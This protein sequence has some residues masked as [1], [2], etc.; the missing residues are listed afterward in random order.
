MNTS[1]VSAS[2]AAE[3][4]DHI[5]QHL[6][7]L[8]EACAGCQQVL[9]QSLTLRELALELLR[10]R[11]NDLRTEVGLVVSNPDALFLNY[12]DKDG[13]LGSMAM[14]DVLID[15][16]RQSASVMTAADAAFYTRHDSLDPA[17]ALTAVQNQKLK[18]LLEDFARILAGSYQG[19]LKVF[20]RKTLASPANPGHFD[21]ARQILI[22]QHRAALHSEIALRAISRDASADDKTRL[23]T[24]IDSNAPEGVFTLSWVAKDGM[25]V[26]LPFAY[27]VNEMPGG[28][29]QPSGAVYLV[30]PGR[31]IEHI[32]SVALVRELLSERL[33]DI[34][35][36][37][38]LRDSLLLSDQARLET[39]EVVEP[40]AWVFESLSGPLLS[41]HVR[42]LQHKQLE[43]L[44]FLLQGI[45]ENADT[46]SFHSELDRVRVCGH[47]D[48]AMGR[49]F[50]S[51][52][53]EMGEIVQPDWR[54]YGDQG[55]KDH[56][57]KLES[58]YHQSKQ[59]LEGVLAGVSSLENFARDEI[60]TYVRQHLGCFIDPDKVQITLQDAI[61]LGAGEELQMRY[62]KSLLEF[63]IQGLPE[64]EILISPAPNDLH[65]EFSDR[66]VMTMINDLNLHF[67]YED[68]L[69]RCYADET[70]L[71]SMTHHRDSAIELGA[72]AASMQGHMV[73]PRSHD[74][75]HLIRGDT[76]K[77]GSDFAIGSLYLKQPETRFRDLIVF[78]E[79]IDSDEHFVL[80][81][82]GAPGGQDFFE[83]GSWRQ[84]CIKV[85]EWL[86]LEAGRSYV[87]DQ[88]ASRAGGGVNAVLSHV[89]LKP[90]EWGEDSCVFVRCTG[91]NFETN[92]SDLVRQK[93]ARTIDAMTTAATQAIDQRSRIRPSTLAL[94]EA[95]ITALNAEFARLSPGLVSLREYVHQHTKKLLNDFLRSQD[96]TRE[97]DPD[98]LYVGLGSDRLASPDFSEHSGLKT[99]TELMLQGA[100]DIL[101]YKPDIHL[102]SSTGLNVR[103]LPLGL[104]KFMDKQIREADLAADYMKDL[105]RSYLSRSSRDYL[106]RKAVMG[107]R[108]QYDMQRAALKAF[109]NGLLDE[110]QHAWLTRTI[111]TLG[112]DAQVSAAD[113]ES[114]VAYFRIQGVLVEGVYIFEDSTVDDPDYKLLYTPDS[115]DGIAFRALT[116]YADLLGSGD[117]RSYFSS[118]ISY[119]GQHWYRDFL[120]EFDRSKKHH[121]NVINAENRI[122]SAQQLYVDMIERM[123]ANADAEVQTTAE[124]RLALAWTIIQW[125]GTVLLLPFPNLSFSWGLLTTTVTLSR[126]IDAYAAGD[127][128]T[129]LPLLIF[130][131]LGVVSGGDT[132]RAL[133][134][135]TSTVLKGGVSH[136]AGWAASKLELGRIVREVV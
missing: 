129:A 36:E 123:I 78:S 132:A 93:T 116:N 1:P 90:T 127:R 113:G 63:A 38:C 117:M 51:L 26:R 33:A 11:V 50:N 45:G 91:E 31:G 13:T 98:T 52:A 125:S 43:D 21:S 47:L 83:F 30:R 59:T 7:G 66:F 71:R 32:E 53:V 39:D 6:A 62:Q 121:A 82:P 19:H 77:Q 55:Q 46:E 114:S 73:Q 2:P 68:K 118:R 95:R 107:K 115:P 61:E 136:A 84:L 134:Q 108:I 14:T 133:I 76:S 3:R 109:I 88:L 8:T 15:A 37:E 106:R 75:L 104:I 12:R 120:E 126:G 112:P 111:D 70:T 131:V 97:I 92:L 67:R 29:D 27:V 79:K 57:D 4:F 100:V 64:G 54:K 60:S 23:S 48:D 41:A 89:E 10:S 28:G 16:M 18:E 9:T 58:L 25:P 101:S 56:L 42:S 72:W 94:V 105:S 99:F 128:A 69:R 102:Y 17:H 24:V 119:S 86:A 74:L 81:A 87:R 22:E 85:G 35:A 5:T 130:G 103:T 40:G 135:G 110:R 20:W 122:R 65:A 80:Y 49:R 124:K 34:H 44:K 96:Y